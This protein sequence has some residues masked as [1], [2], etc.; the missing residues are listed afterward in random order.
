MDVASSA[1]ERETRKLV[2][3]EKRS[4]QILIVF[5][6][7]SLWFQSWSIFLGLLLGGAVAVLNF[8]WLGMIMEKVFFER[9]RLHGIQ[10][11]IKFIVLGTLIFLIVQYTKVNPIALTAGLST[12]FLGIL[13]EGLGQSLGSGKEK[14]S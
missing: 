1:R 5:L 9:K 10:I 12:L 6:L 7:T 14:G 11:L 4:V 13:I 3:I 8:C 2:A